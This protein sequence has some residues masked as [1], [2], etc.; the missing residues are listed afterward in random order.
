[1]INTPKNHTK[2]TSKRR[3]NNPLI[4]SKAEDTL[5]NIQAIMPV[6]HNFLANIDL[7][8]DLDDDPDAELNRALCLHLLRIVRRALDHE[9][10]DLPLCD[11]NES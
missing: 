1:M 3:S 9:I 7:D 8:S 2:S 11:S 5:R 4:E 10:E 6:V